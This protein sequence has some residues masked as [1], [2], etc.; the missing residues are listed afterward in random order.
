MYSVC[1]AIWLKKLQYAKRFE[2]QVEFLEETVPVE[3]DLNC[4]IN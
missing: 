2:S 1:Q 4:M 3:E